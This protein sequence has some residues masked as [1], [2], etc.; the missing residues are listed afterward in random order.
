MQLAPHFLFRHH[1]HL[2][3]LA[4]VPS[5]LFGPDALHQVARLDV[6]DLSSR[7][8]AMAFAGVGG[9]GT[10]PIIRWLKVVCNRECLLVPYDCS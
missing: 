3:A 7:A 2:C 4:K 5:T 10:L 1:P 6:I 9:D 8:V